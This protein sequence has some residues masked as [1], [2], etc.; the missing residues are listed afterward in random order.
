MTYF[1]NETIKNLELHSHEIG[2][3][4]IRRPRKKLP[5]RATTKA[6]LLPKVTH[7]LLI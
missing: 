5:T 1:M 2:Q 7:L 6:L 3:K 4:E